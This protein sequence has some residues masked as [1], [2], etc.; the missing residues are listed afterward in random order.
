[1]TVGNEKLYRHELGVVVIANGV[2]PNFHP[3]ICIIFKPKRKIIAWI[4][5]LAIALVLIVKENENGVSFSRIYQIHPNGSRNQFIGYAFCQCLIDVIRSAE[6]IKS[7]K[8][9]YV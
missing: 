8:S 6:G 5:W 4:G 9:S 1:M 2:I 7:I 3:H